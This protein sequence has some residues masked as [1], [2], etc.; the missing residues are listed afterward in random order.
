V[1][2]EFDIG[3]AASHG[4]TSTALT[5]WLVDDDAPICWLLDRAFRKEG[6]LPRIFN[7][8]TP[9]LSA[10]ATEASPDVV[11]TDIK[12]P[13]QSGLDLLRRVRDINPNLPVIVMTAYSDLANAV[14]AYENGAFEYL[15]KP[16][17]VDHVVSLVR[18]AAATM[19][20]SHTKDEGSTVI[21][22]L[23]GNAPAMQQVFRAIGRLGRSSATVLITGESGT[24]KELVARALR[25]H[26]P[27]SRGPFVALN[28]SAIPGDLLEA[29]LFGY[30]RGAFTGA[31]T[32][33]RGRFEQAANG[34]IF[35]DEIGDMST[36]MQTRLLRVLAEG[37]F[38]RV[39]GQLPIQAGARIIAATHR[40]LPE[41]VKQGSFREDLY[42]RL[43]VIQI[44]LPPLRARLEDIPTLLQHYFNVA[45]HE[46]GI[47]S[48]TLTK[49][50][51]ERL[52][53]YRWPGNVRELV[54]LCMRLSVLAPGT[55]IRLE[56]LPPEYVTG[57]AA[58]LLDA[59][60]ARS[61]RTWADRAAM[62]GQGPLLDEALPRFERALIGA[63][64]KRTQGH[65][66]EAAELLG[67]G[68]NTLT[69]KIRDLGMGRGDPGEA[70]LERTQ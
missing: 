49:S 47:E 63:A 53:A 46:L 15:P 60:W 54:N 5:V 10:L 12:L 33:R 17:D 64:L 13:D 44:Q 41:R 35:L 23:L 26:S 43:N 20:E 38:Y 67:W 30:E 11:L 42:H 62:T 25:N 65:R 6:L 32:G 50:C 58:T 68:R 14:S 8:A 55:E 9:A 57:E 28:T 40:H 16:F 24:G 3:N 48:K 34:T 4:R 56:D 7:S 22:E 69:Q 21:P 18:R 27:R 29:E 31:D 37:E 2:E 1:G 19:C 61:L 51:L 66:R 45:A 70:G 36:T 39:G 59:D 52:V